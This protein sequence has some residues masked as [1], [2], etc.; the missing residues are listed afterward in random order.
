M[1]DRFSALKYKT[2]DVLFICFKLVETINTVS[3]ITV[4]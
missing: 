3:Q 4:N 2:K 1:I